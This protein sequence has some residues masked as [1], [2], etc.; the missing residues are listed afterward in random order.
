M[1]ARYEKRTLANDRSAVI[2]LAREAEIPQLLPSAFYDLSRYLPSQLAIDYTDPDTNRTYTLSNND[3]FRV[4]RGKEQAARYFS[5]F[6]VKEL[7][8][9]TPSE[10][11]HNRQEL[12]PSR[13]RRCQMAFEAVTYSLLRDINGLVLN[14]NSDPLFA[15][16]DSLLM[17]TREDAPGTENKTT[18]RACEACRM[19]FGATVNEVRLEFWNKLPEWFDLE[20]PNW[21]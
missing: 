18:M 20:V 14:R 15:I 10:F 7:E 9:R 19:D 17:Q 3:L 2:A 5:T 4:Y 13:K 8:G 1:S 12:Q 11:C 21:S 6:I 16:A